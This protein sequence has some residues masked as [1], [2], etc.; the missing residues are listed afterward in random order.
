MAGDTPITL[1]G[2]LTRDPE[3]SY[4]KSGKAWARFSV[5][6]GSRRKTQDGKWEDGESAF[7][8]CSAFGSIAENLVESLH[9]G[10]R[11]IVTG[12]LRPD[13]Y[14][15]KEGNDKRTLKVIVSN[16]GPSL[17][18][19]TASVTKTQRREGGQQAQGGQQSGYDNDPWASNYSDEPPF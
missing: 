19:A 8:D 12:T 2:G 6:V 16:I 11:V 1:E 18:F 7:W 4:G 5:A 3:L 10:D 15:D 13:V 9:K 17:L 14:K